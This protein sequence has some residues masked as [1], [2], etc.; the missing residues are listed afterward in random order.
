MMTDIFRPYFFVDKKYDI[1]LPA[2]S[3]EGLN[4]LEDDQDG[5]NL[6]ITDIVMCQ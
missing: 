4:L 5:F 1:I 6:I 2:N 3:L